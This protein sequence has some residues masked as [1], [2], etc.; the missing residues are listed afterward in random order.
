MPEK[1][2]D[3]SIAGRAEA[4]L[5]PPPKANSRGP[6]EDGAFADYYL[7]SEL[8]AIINTVYPSLPDA[9]TSDR[10]DLVLILGRGIPGLNQTNEDGL[11]DMLR[12]NMG[13]PPTAKPDALGAVAGDLAGFPNGRRLTDDVVDINVRA[14]ADGYGEFLEGAFGLPNL[15]PNNLVGDGCGANDVKF[16]KAFP[17]LGEPHDGYRGGEYRARCKA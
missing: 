2:V 9:R 3:G 6:S 5:R 10:E 1:S 15:A 8:A 12:L 14:I 13:V 17:Y 7:N 16:R 4:F 11:M